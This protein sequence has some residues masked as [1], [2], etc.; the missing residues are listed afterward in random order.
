MANTTANY[1]R[2]IDVPILGQAAVTAANT[3]RDGSGTLVDLFTAGSSDAGSKGSRVERIVW[4]SAQATAAAS[5]AMVGRVYVTDSSG[6][7][8]KLR[9]EVAIATATA[10][11]TAIGALATI[12]FS[13]GLI[14]PK[15]CKI[16]VAQSVYAGVQDK[17]H[18]TAEG[19]D[20]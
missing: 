2:Y 1:P 3:A 12:T 5:S 4:I 18:V 13:G 16:Q 14:L 20:F 6:S 10:S 15:G 7:N 11:N 8:P 17:M 9:A 19:G